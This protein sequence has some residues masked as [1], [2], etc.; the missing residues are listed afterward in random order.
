MSIVLRDII[1]ARLLPDVKLMGE[2]FEN[3]GPLQ[4]FGARIHLAYA[5]RLYGLAAYNDLRVIKDIRNAFA[6]SAEAMD[7]NHQDVARLCGVLWYPQRISVTNRPDPQTPRQK[8][9]RAI[10]LLTEIFLEDRR[11]QDQGMSREPL[12]MATGPSG[13]ARKTV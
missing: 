13:A 6:H 3:R 10:T 12:I 9:I 2:L 1:A 8:Y 7:F 5:L 4:D 11:R